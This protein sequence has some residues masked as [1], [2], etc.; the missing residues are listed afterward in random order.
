MPKVSVIIPTY[1]RA[2][3]LSQAIQSVLAQTYSDYELIV[4]DDGSTD[5]TKDLIAPYAHQL[6]GRF[7]YIHQQHKNLPSAR[8]TGIRHANG[9]YI[10]FL[11]SDDMWVSTKLEKQMNTIDK[12]GLA[13]VHTGVKH[14]FLTKDKSPDLLPMPKKLAMNRKD[15]L[16]GESFMS[17]TMVVKKDALYQVNLF[18]EN[19][20]T[21]NDTDLWLR[22]TK[23]YEIGCIAEPLVIIHKHDDNLATRDMEQKYSDRITIYEKELKE[24]HPEVP[25]H[26]WKRKLM[27]TYYG[28]AIEKYKNGPYYKSE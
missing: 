1:N 7:K 16:G 20:P 14:V 25:Q 22:F 8:N 15:Y 28:L 19:I 5:S 17:M 3:F 27:N 4:V 24:Q 26:V 12:T 21:T 9:D 6:N 10:A 2:H 23:K 13:L 18:D 11:D